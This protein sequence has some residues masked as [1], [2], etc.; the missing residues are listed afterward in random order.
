[1]LAALQAK[2]I[3]LG[4]V[5]NAGDSQDVFQ[6]VEKFEIRRY[7]DFILTSA[8]CGYRKPHPA[9]FKLA[10]AHWGYMPDEVAMVGDKLE[11]DVHGARPL[12]IYAI[13]IKRRA[14]AAPHPPSRMKP[15]IRWQ[16]SPAA[17]SAYRKQVKS[18][19]LTLP[20]QSA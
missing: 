5:S 15:S 14:K 18:S 7:F 9:I 13:W 6:L 11:A 8:D 2:G 20:N 19:G 17:W 1:M 10:L 4:L 3:R 16:K 12:G